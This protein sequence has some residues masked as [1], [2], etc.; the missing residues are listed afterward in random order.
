VADQAG[1][2]RGAVPARRVGRPAR[3]AAQDE[4]LGVARPAVHRREQAP[5][6][7]GSIGTAFVAKSPPDGYTFAF[8]TQAGFHAELVKAINLPEVRK[9]L[10]ETLGMDVRAAS[11]DATQ[12]FLLAEMARWGK[13]VKDKDIKQD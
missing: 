9:T 7:S 10:T 2:V 13:V 12:K 11:P 8:D 5:G 3:A 1:E 6:A 4:A